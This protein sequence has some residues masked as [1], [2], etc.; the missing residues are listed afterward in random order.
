MFAL[1][2]TGDT[3]IL[4]TKTNDGQIQHLSAFANT[5]GEW[6]DPGLTSDQYDTKHSALPES[7]RSADIGIV[8]VTGTKDYL[9]GAMQKQWNWEGSETRRVEAPTKDFQ[10]D[11]S[12]FGTLSTVPISEWIILGRV[13]CLSL[14]ACEI[15]SI[16]NE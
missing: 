2:E 4:Y 10:I 11:K 14:H 16:I 9:Q 3:I 15:S 8:S 7:L 6:T 5:G 12:S 13:S 1:A